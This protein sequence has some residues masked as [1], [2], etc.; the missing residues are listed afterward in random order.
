VFNLPKDRKCDFTIRCKECNE[1]VPAPVATMPDVWIVAVCP[2][3]G[4]KRR[5]LPAEIFRGTL[6]HR[7]KAQN[8]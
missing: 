2:L 8:V 5:Y 3:C 1:N 7:L 6:S 4:E